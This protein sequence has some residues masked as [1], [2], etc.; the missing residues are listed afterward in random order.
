MSAARAAVIG[1]DD[2][3]VAAFAALA[4]RVRMSVVEVRTDGH[5]AGAGTIW[6]DNGT[7]VTNHHVARRDRAEV[8]LP[9][10]RALPAPVVA[11]DPRNDLAVLR[12]AAT[13]L[14]ALPSGPEAEL[15]PGALVLALG[16]PLGVRGVATI[17]VVHAGLGATRSV[18]ERALIRADVQLAP[19]NSGGPLVDAQ[20][21]VVGINSMVAGGLALAVP[22][23]LAE[24]LV[25]GLEDSPRLAVEVQDVELLPSRAASA[26][27]AARSGVMIVLIE[28]G[29]PADRAGLLIGDII[30]HVDGQAV[31]GVATLGMV[32]RARRDR[33]A[34]SLSCGVSTCRRWLIPPLEAAKAAA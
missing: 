29:G 25:A 14:P 4:E 15:R 19:G 7:I 18:E 27:I 17:G 8:I 13:G 2:G 24:R 26:G 30:L 5:G 10:G 16:H 12:V 11:R 28:P 6:R 32:L 33:T 23:Y 21:R 22:S 31:D 34:R 20:G 3:L 1:T 9:D